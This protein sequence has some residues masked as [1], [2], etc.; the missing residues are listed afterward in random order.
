MSR[1][2]TRARDDSGPRRAGGPSW[3]S[4]AEDQLVFVGFERDIT[5]PQAHRREAGGRQE[6]GQW[7]PLAVTDDELENPD[8][9]ESRVQPAPG[10]HGRREDPVV[11][12]DRGREIPR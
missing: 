8:E 6:Q 11:I 5:D 12:D 1:N 10:L 3:G 9:R 2:S 7:G 4:E